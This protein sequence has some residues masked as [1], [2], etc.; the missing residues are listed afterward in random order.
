ML[1][2]QGSQKTAAKHSSVIS[3]LGSKLVMVEL[4]LQLTVKVQVNEVDIIL[5]SRFGQTLVEST[6][7]Y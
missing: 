7:R 3:M 1:N 5:K 6:N 2:G 4:P